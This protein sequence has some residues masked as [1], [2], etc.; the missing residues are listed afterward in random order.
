MLTIGN[1][2][3]LFAV[4]EIINSRKTVLRLFRKIRSNLQ[5][6]HLACIF[7]LDTGH[8]ARYLRQRL[9]FGDLQAAVKLMPESVCFACFQLLHQ[10]GIKEGDKQGCRGKAKE[11][12]THS[13]H[14]HILYPTCCTQVNVFKKNNQKP[15]EELVIS[16]SSLVFHL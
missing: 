1:T 3:N 8:P 15:S 10:T 5:V 9:S 11:L 13:Q 7:G 6:Q 16:S 12:N 4:P 14:S 2:K